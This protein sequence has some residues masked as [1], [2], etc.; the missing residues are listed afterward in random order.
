MKNRWT[1][2]TLCH[3]ALYNIAVAQQNRTG[4][5]LVGECFVQ[6]ETWHPIELDSLLIDMDGKCH[7]SV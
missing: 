2:D 6:R 3:I 1:D 7:E 5:Y 4:Q